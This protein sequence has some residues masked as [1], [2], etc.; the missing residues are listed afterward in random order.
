[1]GYPNNDTIQLFAEIVK[2]DGIEELMEKLIDKASRDP[3][4]KPLLGFFKTT[5][6][7]MLEDELFDEV[8]GYST[9][10]ITCFDMFRRQIESEKISLEDLLLQVD[11]LC[12]WNSFLEEESLLIKSELER[13]KKENLNLKEEINNLN[14]KIDELNKNKIIDH[15]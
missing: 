14:N 2:R 13:L 10:F 8:D 5:L 6:T 4:M 12:G 7:T 1:M 3:K 9:G 15:I 11:N